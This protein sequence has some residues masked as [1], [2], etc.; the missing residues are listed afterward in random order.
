MACDLCSYTGPTLCLIPCCCHLEILSKF[1]ARGLIF[2]FF[3][4]STHSIVNPVRKRSAKKAVL[5]LHIAFLSLNFSAKVLIL[6]FLMFREE[7]SEDS[8]LVAI[9]KVGLLS[10][11]R[12]LE[13]LAYVWRSFFLFISTKIRFHCCGFCFRGML[14]REQGSYRKKERLK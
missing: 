14:F 4:G 7:A 6:S 13:Y 1:W 8:P 11:S 12:F 9:I 3:L 2:S 10:F 5:F